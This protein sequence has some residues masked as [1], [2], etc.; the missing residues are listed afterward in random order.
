M[1]LTMV[2]MQWLRINS[3][4]QLLQHASAAATAA[5]C[6]LV[7]RDVVLFTFLSQQTPH[8]VVIVTTAESLAACCQIT[9]LHM[10]ELTVN[11]S[12]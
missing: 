7:T 6:A 10:P 3:S 4:R 11:K 9:C 12:S 5:T 2:M 8:V 1:P